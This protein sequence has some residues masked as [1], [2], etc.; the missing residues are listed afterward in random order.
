MRIRKHAKPY[1][2]VLCT[3]SAS[4]DPSDPSHVPTGPQTR[5]CLLNRSRWDVAGLSPQSPTKY[6][7]VNQEDKE[8]I[9]IRCSSGRGPNA[10]HESQSDEI[11][12]L[13][14]EEEE[15]EKGRPKLVTTKANNEKTKKKIRV[16]KHDNT[17]LTR[18]AGKA[19]NAGPEF[20]YYS[21]FGPRCGRR[22]RGGV[23]GGEVCLDVVDSVVGDGELVGSGGGGGEGGSSSAYGGEEKNVVKKRGRKRLKSR[24]LKSLL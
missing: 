13:H 21:G 10:S 23:G 8:D 3:V 5:V 1:Q 2:V 24:S 19:C 9:L 7:Q 16:C 17:T 15:K 18:R 22:R 11:E 12:K 6:E 20:Y 14:I 4:A